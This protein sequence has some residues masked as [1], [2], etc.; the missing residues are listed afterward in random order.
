MV[1]HRWEPSAMAFGKWLIQW[2]KKGMVAA[3]PGALKNYVGSGEQVSDCLVGLW[4]LV[5]LFGHES[6]ES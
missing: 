4:T 5:L 2:Y 6:L 3:F 1:R